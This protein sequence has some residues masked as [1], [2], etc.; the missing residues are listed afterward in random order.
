ML[1]G[2]KPD[3]FICRYCGMRTTNNMLAGCSCA[4]SPTKGHVLMHDRDFY[5]CKWCGRSFNNPFVVVS[6]CDKSPHG[7]HEIME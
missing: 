5:N 2:T 4:T 1:L 7:T 3:K 6:Q